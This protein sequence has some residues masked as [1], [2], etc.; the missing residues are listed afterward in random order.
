MEGCEL[1]VLERLT[2]WHYEDD[3]LIICDCRTCGTPMLVFRKHGERAQNEHHYARIKLLELYRKRL[4]K[5][6]VKA[7]KVKEHEHWH[8]YL[9]DE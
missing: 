2:P 9:K 6:R 7:R 4:I 3:V 8:I 5:I 1:C